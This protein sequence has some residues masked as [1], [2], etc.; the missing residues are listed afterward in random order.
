MS[1]TK[2]PNERRAGSQD[3]IRK[4]KNQLEHPT[5]KLNP[6]ERKYSKG[7]Q[8]EVRKEMEK[9]KHGQAY[10]GHSGTKVKSREQAIA[11]GL[12]EARA[13]GMKAPKAPKKA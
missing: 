1:K 10:S 4:E 11:I 8:E 13:K 9:F 12:S 7:S 2:L 3:D 5:E 6:H